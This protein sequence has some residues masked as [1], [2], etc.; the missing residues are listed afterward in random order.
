MPMPF[1][2]PAGCITHATEIET[3]LMKIIG[4][5]PMSW[6]LRIACAA[7]FGDAATISTSAPEACSD[8]DLAVHG[9]IGRLIAMPPSTILSK[10]GAEHVPQPST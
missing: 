3:L 4:F 7:I 6:T 9:R 5:Q 2:G 8:D 10:L 1:S